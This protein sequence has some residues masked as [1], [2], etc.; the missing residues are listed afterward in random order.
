LDQRDEACTAK[1]EDVLYA[2]P[3]VCEFD[4]NGWSVRELRRDVTGVDAQ[5]RM[6]LATHRFRTGLFVTAQLREIAE[7]LVL[8][9]EQGLSDL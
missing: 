9:L 5:R 7:R 6:L 4:L 8:A 3:G 2:V 1:A